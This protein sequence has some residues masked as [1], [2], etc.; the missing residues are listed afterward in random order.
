[1]F[2]VLPLCSYYDRFKITVASLHPLLG[3]T[4]TIHYWNVPLS[5]LLFLSLGP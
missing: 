3:L 2:L 4:V 5:L 1:M